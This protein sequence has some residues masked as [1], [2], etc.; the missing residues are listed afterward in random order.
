MV[1]LKDVTWKREGKA[2]L[3]HISW[4]VNEN[5]HWVILGLNGSGKTSILNVLTGYQW[6]SSG[7]VQVLGQTFGETNVPELRKSIGWVSSSVD[8]RFSARGTDTALEVVLSGKHAS[9]GL[10]EEVTNDD[11]IRA[12]KWLKELHIESLENRHVMS[13]SQGEKRRVMI[14][15]A[16]MA[17]PDILILDEPCN[18]LDIF[19]REQLLETIQTLATTKGGPTLLYV[20]HHIEEVVPAISHALLIH[21]GSIVAKGEKRTTLTENNLEKTFQLPVSLTWEDERLWVSIKSKTKTRE[22]GLYELSD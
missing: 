19:S 3:N 16:L 18:G 2:I 4:D 14:A 5:E 12:K 11:K 7:V 15:R 9:I 6:A 22:V 10:Y 17:S 20:T 8:D 21:N 13:L 1:S